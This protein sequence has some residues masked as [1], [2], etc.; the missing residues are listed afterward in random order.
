MNTSRKHVS[1][2]CMTHFYTIEPTYEYVCIMWLCV[3]VCVVKHGT[4][5]LS[6]KQQHVTTNNKLYFIFKCLL[7]FYMLQASIEY[8]V[9]DFSLWFRFNLWGGL[10]VFE[11]ELLFYCCM[12]A[13]HAKKNFLKYFKA[14]LWWMI[15]I[16]SL[17]LLFYN[18]HSF[19]KNS[20]TL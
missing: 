7:V 10:G 20:I 9:V 6:N 2:C 5:K 18:L 8:I 15:I 1:T 12:R 13:S 17:L 11:V 19:T 3:C 16:F 14:V 4:I